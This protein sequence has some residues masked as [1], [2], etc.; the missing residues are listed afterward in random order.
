MT[1]VPIALLPS[2]DAEVR[3][4]NAMQQRGNPRNADWVKELSIRANENKLVYIDFDLTSF[5]GVA[6]SR[7]DLILTVKQNDAWPTGAGGLRVYAFRE[8]P[9]WDEKSIF[10]R[11][12]AMHDGTEPLR[13]LTNPNN[14]PGLKA[15][16]MENWS[17]PPSHLPVNKVDTFNVDSTKVTLLGYLD[18]DASGVTKP[19]LKAGDKLS[20][21][22]NNS[23]TGRPENA[24]NN[25]AIVAF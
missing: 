25:T 2:A 17:P 11:D 15:D 8:A 6:I 20:F 4:S 5:K 14:A 23:T 3:E 21:T 19:R 13:N 12:L 10:Y 1:S 7:A 22:N 9:K 16:H 24:K 18:Y